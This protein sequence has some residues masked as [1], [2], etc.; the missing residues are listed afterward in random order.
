MGG[1]LQRWCANPSG[2]PW[3]ALGALR[4][5]AVRA[6]R[7]VKGIPQPAVVVHQPYHPCPSL[8]CSGEGNGV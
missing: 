8:S 4:R 6:Q 2:E 1:G 5:Y 3:H 7:L